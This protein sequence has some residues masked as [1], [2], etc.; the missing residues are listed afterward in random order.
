M[1]RPAMRYAISN[2]QTSFSLNTRHDGYEGN[3]VGG[4]A[5]EEG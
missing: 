1:P 5:G 4:K 3:K 2:F